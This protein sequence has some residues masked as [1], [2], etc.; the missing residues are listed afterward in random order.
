MKRLY[1]LII[2]NI[3]ILP[4]SLAQKQGNIWY[5][6]DSVGVDFNGTNPLPLLNGVIGGSLSISTI[7]DSNGNLLFYAGPKYLDNFYITIINRQ[8][9]IMM[10]GD[11][12]LGSDNLAQSTLILPFPGDSERY[13]LFTL[14]YNTNGP[15]KLAY[16]IINMNLDSGLGGVEQKNILLGL[17]SLT[18]MMAAVRHANGRDWWL[19]VHKYTN[20]EYI[21]YLINTNGISVPYSQHIGAGFNT[22]DILGGMT[23][24]QDGSKLSTCGVGNLLEVFDFDRCSGILSNI[25]AIDNVSGLYSCSFSPNGKVLYASNFQS[26]YQYDLTATNIINSMQ[27][28]FTI[29]PSTYWIGQ[30]KLATNN[31][32]Y[33]AATYHTLPN[34]FYDTITMNLSVI[35][36]PDSLGAACN[37]APYSFNLGGRR[38]YGGLPNIPNYNLGASIT[39]VMDSAKA[40]R[41]TT[42]CQGQSLLLGSP[43]VSGCV[44]SWSPATGLDDSTKAQPT[45]APRQTTTYYLTL[46]DTNYAACKTILTT[47]DSVVITVIPY[48]TANAGKDISICL[49]DTILIGSSATSGYSY[50][51]KPSASLDDSTKAEPM[52]NPSQTTSFTLTVT[53]TTNNECKS[54]STTSKIIVTVNDCY[55]N[56]VFPNP[57]NGNFTLEFNIQASGIFNLYDVL[58]QELLQQPLQGEAGIQNI[59]SVNLS[60]GIYFWEIVTENGVAAKG[61]IGIIK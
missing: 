44:Y 52:A 39:M 2:I 45:A 17:D 12:I 29:T 3:F 25:I 56:K 41:D 4:D 8:Q 18:Q 20:D 21:E 19:L 48:N 27:T 60:N 7:A 54:I 15:Q 16:S 31:K 38:N 22:L 33:V 47:K 5:F 32:I 49:G 11:N 23:F 9:Q 6:G 40:G 55:I 57:N 30:H 28:I 1:L 35:N 42:I 37:F 34:N 58:G 13:F 46:T 51:W 10:N 36:T 43:L 61:K 26:L 14:V 50:L 59:Y 24:S 53:D